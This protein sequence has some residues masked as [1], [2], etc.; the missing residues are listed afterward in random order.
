MTSKPIQGLYAITDP[1]LCPN[2][3]LIDKVNQAI[4]GGAKII[5]YR[6]K[7]QPFAVQKAMA[8]KLAK[9]CKQHNVLFIVN[10]SIELAQY[11]QA[12]GIHL[13]KDDTAIQAARVALG[14]QA[15]IGISCYNSLERAQQMQNLGADYVAFGRFFP[16]KTKQNA[17]QAEIKTLQLAKQKLKIPL[18]A[19]GGINTDNA[20]QLLDSGADSIAVIQ[21]IF[22]QANIQKSAHSLSNLFQSDKSL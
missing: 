1:A 11:S 7:T 19:I 3:T 15:I 18:V 17:P 5:Q 16:S 14:E 13:G 6:D 9:L 21:G 12:D 20:Q 8:H 22:A 4:D 10:D 2:D